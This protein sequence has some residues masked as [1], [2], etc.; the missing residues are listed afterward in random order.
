MVISGIGKTYPPPHATLAAAHHARHAL[1][2]RRG[3]S[4]HLEAREMEELWARHCA[5]LLTGLKRGFEEC[6]AE[7]IR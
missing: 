3:R 6:L 5:A 1:Q 7:K 4:E 2:Q